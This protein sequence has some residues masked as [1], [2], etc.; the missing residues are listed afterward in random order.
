[1]NVLIIRLISVAKS[2]CATCKHRASGIPFNNYRCSH[3]CSFNIKTDFIFMIL[4]SNRWVSFAFLTVFHFSSHF[5]Q[6]DLVCYRARVE[7][8]L[9]CLRSDPC[10][11]VKRQTTHD[12]SEIMDRTRIVGR[13][14][15]RCI[16]VKLLFYVTFERQS[17]YWHWWW[18]PRKNA[19]NKN[20]IHASIEEASSDTET[21]LFESKSTILSHTE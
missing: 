1:M 10:A 12:K 16:F 6:F 18:Q 5:F 3:S 9:K 7:C 13:T 15:L 21:D 19:R 8:V 4:C 17:K 11:Q 2:T 20:R 14:H